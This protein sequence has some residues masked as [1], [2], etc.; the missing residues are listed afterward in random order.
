MTQLA[1]LLSQNAVSFSTSLLYWRETQDEF[2]NSDGD[3]IS[4]S[5]NKLGE[6]RNGF[7]FSRLKT[8]PNGSSIEPS[9]GLSAAYNFDGVRNR[10]PEEFSLGRGDIRGR[11]DAGIIFNEANGLS[12]NATTFYDGI[13]IEAYES[14]GGSVR[15]TKPLN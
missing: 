10:D 11:I 5:V 14:Y 4:K 2:T 15:I 3:V 8:S 1:I 6:T 12:I 13:G 7:I 9:L